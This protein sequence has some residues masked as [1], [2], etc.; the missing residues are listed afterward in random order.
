MSETILKAE[1]LTRVFSMGEREVVGI[2][3]IDLEVK[4]G[5]SMAIRGPSGSGKTTLLTILGCLDRPTSGRLYLDGVDVTDL[6]E[7]ELASVRSTTIGFVFQNFNLMPFLNARENVELP[8][9][10]T[11]RSKEERKDRARELLGLVG[12][13]DREDH[14][15]G[16]LSAGEQ[17]RVAIARSLANEPTILLADEPTGN[18]DSKNKFEIIRLIK[19]LSAQ[20][21]MTTLMVTHDSRVA[22]MSERVIVIKDGRIRLNKHQAQA[23]VEEQEEEEYLE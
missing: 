8:M 1:G 19:R 16:K 23:R 22:S 14:R 18:L 20:Q 3:S 5:E 10:L 4:K 15:P 11:D 17:Q 7:S 12:L 6:P 13:G 21:G 2:S 9:E